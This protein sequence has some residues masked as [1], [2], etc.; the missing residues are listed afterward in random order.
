MIFY[1][2]LNFQGFRTKHQRDKSTSIIWQIFSL[3]FPLD[4]DECRE[5]LDI[6]QNGACRNLAGTYICDCDSGY[7]RSADG[8]ECEGKIAHCG[9]KETAWSLPTMDWHL[10]LRICLFVCFLSACLLVLFLTRWETCWNERVLHSL[11]DTR[12]GLCFAVVR[13]NMCEAVTK[14]MMQVRKKECCCTA[15]KAWGTNCQLCPRKGTGK[16][17]LWASS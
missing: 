2:C 1:G 6:C 11:L 9:F 17:F 14:E 7:Q 15:G 16:L 8:K 5:K 3:T 10:I 4:I 13:N 12:K